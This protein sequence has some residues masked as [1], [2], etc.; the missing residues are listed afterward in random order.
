MRTFSLFCSS[1]SLSPLDNEHCFGTAKKKWHAILEHYGGPSNAFPRRAAFHGMWMSLKSIS[2]AHIL[3][4]FKDTGIW[5]YCSSVISKDELKRNREVLE[6][7][8]KRRKERAPVPSPKDSLRPQS[9]SSE[10]SSGLKPK[11]G[12]DSDS[13][14][15]YGTDNTIPDT[16]KGKKA[17]KRATEVGRRMAATDMP[18][19]N[20]RELLPS[21]I[22]GL[23]IPTVLQFKASMEQEMQRGIDSGEKPK[24][25]KIRAPMAVTGHVLAQLVASKLALASV[26]EASRAKKPRGKRLLKTRNK[27]ASLIISPDSK[28]ALDEEF[29][30]EEPGPAHQRRRV[31]RRSARQL[32]SVDMED[33]DE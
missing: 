29:I 32:T 7:I 33:L 30:E 25:F 14:S 8:R 27:R 20:I 28:R 10:E 18:K 22:E 16:W 21:E 13:S 5:P 26:K 11:D 12:D 1:N 6:Q 31:V 9:R 17:S 19:R 4:G 3:E 2:P 23:T 15:G 24:L